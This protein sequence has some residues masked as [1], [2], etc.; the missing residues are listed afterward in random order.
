[1]KKI[2]IVICNFN[3]KDFVISCIDSVLK[4]T[5][6]DFDLYVVDNASTDGSVDAIK[7]MQGDKLTLIENKENLGGSGGFNSGLREALK[8]NYEYYMCVDNDIEMEPDNVEKLFGF[9]CSNKD[10]GIVGSKICRMQ[11]RDHLQELGAMIDFDKCAIAPCYKD[12]LDNSDIPKVQYCDYVPACS[13][14]IRKEVI[15]KIGLMPEENFIYWDDMEWGYRAN[16]AGFKV[17]AYREAKVYHDM[18]TNSGMTYFSTYYFWRNRLK[19][20]IKYTPEEKRNSMKNTLLE[21]FFQAMYG[22]CY[23]GKTNQIHI[24]MHAMDDAIHSNLGKA[25]EGVI[26]PKDEIEDRVL[27]LISKYEKIYIEFD[28]NYKLLQDILKK[29]DID[30]KNHEVV[31]L[32]DNIEEVSKQNPKYKVADLNEKI[33]DEDACLRFKMCEHVS[34]VKDK[35]LEVIYIDPYSNILENERDIKHF[36]GY[37]YNR[38]MFIKMWGELI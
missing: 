31:I 5:M 2:G 23:K 16:Q 19:F 21:A 35:S 25:A 10:V 32:A 20:F 29:I 38:D 22:C 30:D 8:N 27:I 26:L 13:L 37:E 28:G 6:Q 4:Q 9:L 17:A 34:K 11:Y 33:I 15:D 14:M 7:A 18:G 1:M 36:E 12:H 24:M 3:K